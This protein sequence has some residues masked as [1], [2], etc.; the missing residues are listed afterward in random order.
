MLCSGTEGPCAK[1][2]KNP[3]DEPMDDAGVGSGAFIAALRLARCLG[4]PH[5]SGLSTVNRREKKKKNCEQA[6]EHEDSGEPAA[7]EKRINGPRYGTKAD[8]YAAD[9]VESQAIARKHEERGHTEYRR[10]K[11]GRA[12]SFIRAVRDCESVE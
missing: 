9:D 5:V 11:N 3:I 6:D 12:N 10:A 2:D 1:V 8:T 7:L 4:K